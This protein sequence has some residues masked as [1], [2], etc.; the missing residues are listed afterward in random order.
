MVSVFLMA[1]LRKTL[2]LNFSL[3]DSDPICIFGFFFGLY[4]LTG[5]INLMIHFPF[6]CFWVHYY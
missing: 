2:S 5:T 4:I 6:L 3:F 1:H